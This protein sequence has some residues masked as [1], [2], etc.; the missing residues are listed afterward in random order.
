MANVTL[1]NMPD[2]VYEGL[3]RKAER[4]RRSLNQEAI[5]LLAEAVERETD[6][7]EDII[8]EIDAFR[9]TLSPA[10]QLTNEEINRFKRAGRE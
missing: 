1:R 3:K 10:F 5:V 7:V 6:S 9:L 2:K 4:N 8:A